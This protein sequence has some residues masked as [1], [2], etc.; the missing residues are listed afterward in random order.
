LAESL[1]TLEYGILLPLSVIHAFPGV[2]G[3]RK[4][5]QELMRELK[6][7]TKQNKTKQN[8]TSAQRRE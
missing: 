6:N 8:K 7:K 2:E 4:L 5:S 1:S 3:I